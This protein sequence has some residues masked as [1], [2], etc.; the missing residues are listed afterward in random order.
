MSVELV[1]RG[2]QA[3]ARIRAAVPQALEAAAVVVEAQAKAIIVEKD[4]IDTGNLLNSVSYSVQGDS[5]RV[6]TNVEYGVYQEYGT[7]RMEARP[8]L[9]PAVDEHQDEIRQAFAA[10]MKRALG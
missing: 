1:W 8:W 7:S 6:G 10:Q 4:I 2:R 5:A 3:V 9:R